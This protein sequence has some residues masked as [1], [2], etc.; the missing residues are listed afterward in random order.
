MAGY[1]RIVSPAAALETGTHRELGIL[2]VDFCD[3]QERKEGPECLG[4]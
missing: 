1:G 2:P 4:G 3:A